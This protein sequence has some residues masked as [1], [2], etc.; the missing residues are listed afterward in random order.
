MQNSQVKE[1]ILDAIGNTPL[2]RLSKIAKEEG[3]ECEFLAK[4]EFMNP[5]GSHK[6]RLALYLIEAAEKEGGLKKGG[7]IIEATSGNTGVAL[8]FVGA[9]KGYNV[10]TVALPKASS[11]KC[12]FIRGF[13]GKVIRAKSNLSKD[14]EGMNNVAA[15][16]AKE[17]PNSVFTS[18]FTNKANVIGHYLKTA[19]EIYNQCG[20]KIDYFFMSAG[21]GG[22]ISGC[23][24]KLKEKIPG[25]KVIGCDPQGS[26]IGGGVASPFLTEGVGYDW[27]PDNVDLKVMDEWIKFDDRNAFLMSRRLMKT[28]GLSVG[29]SAGGI[30][31][32][33]MKYAKEKKLTKD[34]R[35]IVVLPDTG[36]NYLSKL[37]SNEWM[38]EHGFIEEEEYRDLM[39]EPE[40]KKYDKFCLKDIQCNPLQVVKLDQTV[41]GIWKLLK[42]KT[43]ILVNDSGL[44]TDNNYKGM[45]TSKDALLAISSGKLTFDTKIEKLMKKEYSLMSEKLKAST[46]L[47]MLETR[48]YLLFVKEATKEICIVTPADIMTKIENEP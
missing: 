29:G 9:V 3:V 7:T 30:V 2:I 47:K 12:D 5:T 42:E 35:I 44:A 28:E 22:T 11:E 48:E 6:D 45:I 15:R 36:R 18:Q 24:K 34:Q 1:S 27:V 38:F 4:C 16:I 10:V 8:A 14:P 41:K 23:G 26:V 17:T 46:A 32:A 39:L 40:L 37:I 21:T 33:A 43:Y 31:W 25:I 13:G 20:G 19:E